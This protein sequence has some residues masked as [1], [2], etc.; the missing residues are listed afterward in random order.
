MVLMLHLHRQSVV[1]SCFAEERLE[2]VDNLRPGRPKDDDLVRVVQACLEHDPHRSAKSIAK[3]LGKS[4]ATITARLSAI[5]LKYFYLRWVP[6]TLSDE[7]KQRRVEG[8]GVLLSCL[9]GF[10]SRGLATFF[11][12]DESWFKH[13][14]PHDAMWSRTRDEAGTREAGTIV[15]EKTLIVVF[16]SMTGFRHVVAVPR[17]KL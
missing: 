13:D 10:G 15:K 7:Q 16:W 12:A 14:N 17:V 6:H 2:L 5:G 11:T 1:G 8:A 4:V 9:E 3:E